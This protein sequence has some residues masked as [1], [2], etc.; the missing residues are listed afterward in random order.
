MMKPIR[1]ERHLDSDTLHLPELAALIG[2]DVEIIVRERNEEAKGK[3]ISLKGTILKD[4]APFDPV[5]P[6][7]HWDQNK[8]PLAGS[9][10]RY[11][12]PLA[13]AWPSE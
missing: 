12:R 1:I 3:R 2:K 11:D 10:L 7:E 8:G 4:E 5:V 6:P 13:P 9:V